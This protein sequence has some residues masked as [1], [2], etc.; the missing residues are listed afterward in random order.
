M[1]KKQKYLIPDVGVISL[2]TTQETLQSSS[3]NSTAT[4]SNFG[5]TVSAGSDFDS[6]FE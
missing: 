5:G 2:T 6:L 1:N 3:K 4:G